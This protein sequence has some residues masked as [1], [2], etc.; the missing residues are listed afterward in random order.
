MGLP[1]GIFTT[2]T[3]F[4]T[5]TGGGSSSGGLSSI[6]TNPQN[7]ILLGSS[8][9]GSILNRPKGLSKEQQRTSDAQQRA[10]Q[11]LISMLSTR[12]SQPATVDPNL[13]NML[14][15]QAAES[16]VGAQ[17]RGLNALSRRGLANS[18]I[19]AD[20]L[21]DV[22]REQ[23]RAQSGIDLSL[24]QMAEAK[25]SQDQAALLSALGIPVQPNQ[26]GQSVGGAALEGFA[27]MLAYIL[28]LQQLQRQAGG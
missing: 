22:S 16:A 7:L 10:L 25:K 21:G 9:L 17:N 27:P 5:G 6:F 12:A 18:G 15:G 4:P 2:P 1:P 14:Y 3:T 20:Y 23:Q 11:S 19:T 8:I 13:R 28:R 24:T 26:T